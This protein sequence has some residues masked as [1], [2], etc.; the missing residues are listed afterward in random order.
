MVNKVRHDGH[1]LMCILVCDWTA[2][3]KGRKRVPSA[4]LGPPN[5]SAGAGPGR[6]Q[7][8]EP[9][10]GGEGVV[11]PGEGWAA[12][13]GGRVAEPRRSRSGAAPAGGTTE[14]TMRYGPGD[15][16]PRSTFSFY[17]NFIITHKLS[18]WRKQTHTNSMKWNL[19]RPSPHSFSLCTCWA[20][21]RCL[22]G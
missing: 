10:R 2:G 13:S 20:E 17:F 1:N 11:R 22:D 19:N 6:I 9:A 21:Q 3:V 8:A 12:A 15:P 4:A 14:V 5:S 18:H 7:R 16:S